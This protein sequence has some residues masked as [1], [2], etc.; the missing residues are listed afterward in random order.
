MRA[1]WGVWYWPVFLIVTSLLFLGP[2]IYAL[3]TNTLNT[4]SDYASTQLGLNLSVTARQIHNAAWFL[5]QG[6]SLVVVIW[7]WFHIWYLK[8][9]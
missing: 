2:E 6:V 5:T 8:F 4:L 3:L 1:T 9:R 7:L